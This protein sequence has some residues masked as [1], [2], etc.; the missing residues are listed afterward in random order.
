MLACL[1]SDL[2]FLEP[3]IAFDFRSELHEIGFSL[4]V[5]GYALWYLVLSKGIFYSMSTTT[6]KKLCSWELQSFKF[7]IWHVFFNFSN[8]CALPK[9]TNDHERIMIIKGSGRSLA[10]ETLTEGYRYS[11]M[12]RCIVMKN[13]NRQTLPSLDIQIHY[14]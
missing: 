10:S 12:V 2:P 9:L 7:Q 13:N 5:L 8:Y 4:N 11:A 6:K 3:S 1:F 14:S